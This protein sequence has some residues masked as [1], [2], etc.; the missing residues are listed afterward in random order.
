MSKNI[1]DCGRVYDSVSGVYACQDANHY[2]VATCEW[3][4]DEN[5]MWHTGCGNIFEFIV[6]TPT[7]NEAVYCQYCGRRIKEVLYAEEEYE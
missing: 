7:E 6:G 2:E 4:Q 1:C 5:G 3:Q